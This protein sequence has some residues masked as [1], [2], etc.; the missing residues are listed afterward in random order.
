MTTRT[1]ARFAILIFLLLSV[2]LSALAARPARWVK[3]DAWQNVPG[4]FAA[5]GVA[6]G[7]WVADVGARDGYLTLRLA[8]AVDDRGRVWAVDIDDEALDRLRDTLDEEEIGNVVVVHSEPD[9]PKLP[10][11]KF[12]SVVIVN[13][14]HEMDK[15]A[16][17]LEHISRA[18]KP[19]GRLVLVEAIS[20]H[21]R[22]QSRSRQTSA[23]EIEI[24]YVKEEVREAGFEIVQ[25]R[26]PFV[27]END[28]GKPMWLLVAV[29]R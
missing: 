10:W 7:A 15:Y 11:S 5:M 20:D 16:S 22:G 12:D 24:A 14:Y 8:D 2:G 18:L 23:H 25:A 1:T 3:R 19:R 17:M 9:D 21:L 13:A 6:G 27:E 28:G 26:D 4:I 29:P